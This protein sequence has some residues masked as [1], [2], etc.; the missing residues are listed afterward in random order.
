MRELVCTHIILE[1]CG[2]NAVLLFLFVMN[3]PTRSYHKMSFK[4]GIVDL[5]SLNYKG[6]L[7][8]NE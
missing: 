2:L 7:I 5:L 3:L 8:G 4:I 6:E 1:P